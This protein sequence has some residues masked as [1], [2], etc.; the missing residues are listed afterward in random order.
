LPFWLSEKF[1]AY[2]WSAAITATSMFA[3]S[4]LFGWQD[5]HAPLRQETAGWLTTSQG[6]LSPLLLS[7]FHA[8]GCA[9]R[10]WAH[11]AL[12]AAVLLSVSATLVFHVFW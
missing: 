10:W 1:A 8:R 4:I 7:P 5:T 9:V 2:L 12:W 11:P 3:T 6:K